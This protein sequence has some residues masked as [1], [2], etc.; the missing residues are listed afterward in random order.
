MV[1]APRAGVASFWTRL[2]VATSWRSVA[3]GVR[4]MVTPW[5]RSWESWRAS[6]PVYG[7][8]FC[9]FNDLG[10]FEGLVLGVFFL[11]GTLW[12]QRQKGYILYF[13]AIDDKELPGFLVT[14]FILQSALDW[15]FGDRN[16][17]APISTSANIK[18]GEQLFGHIWTG[19]VKECWRV[20]KLSLCSPNCSAR[21][22]LF[23][24]FCRHAPC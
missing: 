23:P 11:G 5:N 20:S 18:I 9:H 24:L 3:F 12:E 2:W 21:C 14:N 4:A 10:W 16:I 19:V 8:I 17:C 13:S 15:W 22:C 6:S 7:Q 1:G